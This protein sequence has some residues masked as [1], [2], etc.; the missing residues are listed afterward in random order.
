MAKHYVPMPRAGSYL[1][2]GTG[3]GP[4]SSSKGPGGQQRP[5]VGA[6]VHESP[7]LEGEL[8][9][10]TKVRLAEV[11]R[12]YPNFHLPPLNQSLTSSEDQHV[13]LVH[14][15]EGVSGLVPAVDQEPATG[16]WQSTPPRMVEAVGP[17]VRVL[18]DCD[19]YQLGIAWDSV[20]RLLDRAGVR[21]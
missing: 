6:S 13:T 5:E 7:L 11:T 2:T 16:P 21:S 3:V 10:K 15:S 8:S 17:A 18:A 1:N 14:Q 20:A 19:L 12:A 9:N 4:Q